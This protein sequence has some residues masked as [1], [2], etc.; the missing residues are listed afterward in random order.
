MDAIDL[1]TR[2]AEARARLSQRELDAK[3]AAA[4]LWQEQVNAAMNAAAAQYHPHLDGDMDEALRAA[5]A[6]RWR[7]E[8]DTRSD[9]GGAP[10]VRGFDL[11]LDGERVHVILSKDWTAFYWSVTPNGKGTKCV[12][13]GALADTL[14]VWLAGWR[15]EAAT[16]EAKAAEEARRAE[17]RRAERQ[18]LAAEWTARV[19][20]A[21]AEDEAA[22]RVRDAYM[23]RYRF[24]WPEGVTLT[25]YQAR[26]YAG[27][28]VDENDTPVAERYTAWGLSDTPDAD[29]YFTFADPAQRLKPPPNVVTWRKV[30]ARGVADLPDELTVAYIAVPVPGV[31]RTRIEVPWDARRRSNLLGSYDL[32]TRQEGSVVREMLRETRPVAWVCRALGVELPPKVAGDDTVQHIGG[33]EYPF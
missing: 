3:A 26:W 10:V 31:G 20:S 30:E 14:L 2:I 17:E 24:A 32:F 4:A 29:G 33:D 13:V 27:P 19:L 7:V 23:A 18:A 16:R 8:R 6:F 5:W 11:T 25:L 1:D 28:G 9:R 12:E 22:R 21:Q 15:Q